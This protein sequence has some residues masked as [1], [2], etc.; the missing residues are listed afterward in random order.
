MRFFGIGIGLIALAALSAVSVAAQDREGAKDHPLVSRYAGSTLNAYHQEDYA[1]IEIVRA[2][3]P[4]AGASHRYGEPVGGRL[5]SI[6]YLL[7]AGR[8]PL[9]AFRNYQQALTAGGFAQLYACEL[10]A[11]AERRVNGQGGLAGAVIARRFDG[12]WSTTGPSV[13]WTDNPSYFLSARLARPSGDVYVLLWVTPGFGGGAA[14]VF[15][16]VLEAKP[17]DTGMVTVNAAALDKGLAAEGHVAL[18]GIVFDTGKADIKPESK[19]QLDEIGKLLRQNPALKV[20][21]VGHTDNE[22]TWE[23]NLTLSLRRAEAV[24]ATLVTDQKIAATRLAARGAASMSP[25]ADNRSPA[26]RARNRRVEI[27][28]Q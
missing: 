1:E 12:H 20:Y 25:V 19:P 6:H 4:A 7:P 23:S 8:T 13:E 5:T 24:V 22:G 15:E 17:A 21:V 11:C 3:K 16:F 28:E 27:V 18:Y 9:E 14:G 2:A 10:E 26:G